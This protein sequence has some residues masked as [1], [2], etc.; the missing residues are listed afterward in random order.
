MATHT[1]STNGDDKLEITIDNPKTNDIVVEI[2]INNSN[3]PL[4][5][6]KGTFDNFFVNQ[7]WAIAVAAL[8]A[9]NVNSE[10]SNHALSF[11]TFYHEV[12]VKSS[13]QIERSLPTAPKKTAKKKKGKGILK[14]TD[15]HRKAFYE[16]QVNGMKPQEIAHKYNINISTVRRGLREY[17]SFIDQTIANAQYATN[18]LSAVRNLAATRIT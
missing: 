6:Y 16:D 14:I 18:D 5:T 13:E 9:A 2:R 3:A 4:Y 12:L 1:Y 10:E 7:A 8:S 11:F 15:E 17:K